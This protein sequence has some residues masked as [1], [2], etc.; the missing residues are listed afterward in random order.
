MSFNCF[1]NL[2]LCVIIQLEHILSLSSL[3]SLMFPMYSLSSF[4]QKESTVML[5]MSVEEAV[6]RATQT[7]SAKGMEKMTDLLSM[8]ERERGHICEQ[9]Q[10]VSELTPTVTHLALGL[11]D[12]S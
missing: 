4:H 3:S 2:G 9:A 5:S 6:C 11:M 8:V 12:G 10:W 7:R 1:F